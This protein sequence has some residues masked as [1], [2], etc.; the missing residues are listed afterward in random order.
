MQSPAL[1]ITYSVNKSKSENWLKQLCH[2][3]L[4]LLSFSLLS[5]LLWLI[6][7]LSAPQLQCCPRWATEQ[8]VR[9]AIQMELIMWCKCENALVYTITMIKVFKCHNIVLCKE[10]MSQ[11][12]SL[13]INNQNVWNGIKVVSVFLPLVFNSSGKCSKL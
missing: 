3:S 8:V 10:Q 7:N 13:I 11:N 5:L 12:K 1:N 4:L 9:K 6:F 2:F